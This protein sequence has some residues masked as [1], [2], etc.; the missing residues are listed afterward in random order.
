MFLFL[1]WLQQIIV[2]NLEARRKDYHQMFAHHIIT[3][4]LMCLSYVLNW[5]RIGSA[6]LCAMDFADILLP[7]SLYSICA[8]KERKES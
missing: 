7:V 4:T 8:R 1:V 2:L 6:I 5:T 3:T